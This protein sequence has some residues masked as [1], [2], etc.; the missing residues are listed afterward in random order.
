MT[1]LRRIAASA[2]HIALG[3]LVAACSSPATTDDRDPA[4]LVP[5]AGHATLT[6]VRDLSVVDDGCSYAVSI[7]A[8]EAGRLVPGGWITL[9]PPPGMHVVSLRP[10]GAACP[11]PSQARPRIEPGRSH[12]LQIVRTPA[13]TIQWRVDD[14]RPVP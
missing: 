9:F 10:A 1:L 13:G 2:P 14:D 7:D 8:A 12:R 11:P 5:R 3:S 6:V 4:W